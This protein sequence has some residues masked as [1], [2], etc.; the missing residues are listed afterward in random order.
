[1][2]PI[3]MRLAAVLAALATATV[4]SSCSSPSTSRHAGPAQHNGDDVV[5]AQHM[6]P[7]HAQALDMAAMVPG[8]T[9][10]A[11]L[12]VLAKHI[13]MDQ[14][15][16]IQTLKGMLAQW[17]EAVP[18]EHTGMIM[19]GMV[20]D[21]TMNQ[22]PTLQGP[23]FDTLWIKSMIVHHQGAVTM[24]QTE[25]ARGQ[26]PDALNTAKIILT[27]QQREIAYMNHLLS[28]PQ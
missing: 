13:A 7:H 5:Y 17:G 27:N 11:D 3:V 28:V 1:M 21:A 26:S 10:N 24:A 20:D 2:A 19:E 16:E 15:A 4:V 14:Q 9:T 12:L 23:A 18:P 8:R 25:I 6:I 22:L